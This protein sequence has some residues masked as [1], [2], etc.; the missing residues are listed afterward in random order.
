[1]VVSL[2]PSHR[3][4]SLKNLKNST[5]SVL[6]NTTKTSIDDIQW[7]YNGSIAYFGAWA[8]VIFIAGAIFVKQRDA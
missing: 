5:T 6:I 3:N 2:G 4:K 1:M 8:V 7:D